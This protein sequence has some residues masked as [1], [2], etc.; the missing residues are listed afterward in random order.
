M[1]PERHPLPHALPPSLQASPR[2]GHR[3]LLDRSLPWLSLVT[4]H[5][6]LMLSLI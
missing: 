5:Y 3:A 4:N 6:E 1:A 2:A